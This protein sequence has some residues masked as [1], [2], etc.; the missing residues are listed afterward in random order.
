MYLSRMTLDVTRR[1][2]MM[3][4]ASP[5]MLH[6]AVEQAFS[7]QRQRN[8]WRVDQLNG[9]Y[10]LLILSREKPDLTKAAEQFAPEGE[11]WETKD[12]SALL[13]RTVNGSKWHFRLCANPTYSIPNKGQARGRVCAHS[14][15]AHQREWLINQSK[16]HGFALA[17]DSFDVTRSGWYRF[18]KG[19]KGSRI[20][21]LAVTFEGALTVTDAE[22]F[23]AML[24]DGI[25]REK[26]YGVGLMT[27]VRAEV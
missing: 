21:L 5:S 4:L 26:A 9:Q 23:R 14:T 6:G 22:L 12:Y 20:S 8:L 10:Y 11:T 18:S 16:K 13:K 7:G 25:G 2:T 24:T 1:E 3:A 17:E 19:V 27:L 15:T